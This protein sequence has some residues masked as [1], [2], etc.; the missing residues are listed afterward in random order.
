MMEKYVKPLFLGQIIQK[1]NPFATEYDAGVVYERE[2][3]YIIGYEMCGAEKTFSIGQPV[4]D[5]DGNVMGWL[6]IGLYRNLDYSI[7]IMRVPCEYWEICLPTRYCE[8]GK[9]VYTYWQQH[10]GSQT[11]AESEDKE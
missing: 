2:G 1:R 9:K 5:K 6:G 11:G 7:E 3:H 10:N 4:Y 8:K